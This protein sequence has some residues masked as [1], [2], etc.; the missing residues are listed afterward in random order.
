MSGHSLS[1]HM[2]GD[3]AVE[4]TRQR[5]P[6]VALA[7][8][9]TCV[10]VSSYVGTLPNVPGAFPSLLFSALPFIAHAFVVSS[11]RLHRG[12]GYW[13]ILAFG[14]VNLTI[15]PILGAALSMNL[16]GFESVP[17]ESAMT[18]TS[19]LQAAVFV[20][21]IV[22]YQFSSAPSPRVDFGRPRLSLGVMLLGLG[23][24]G[25]WLRIDSLGGI[26]AYLSGQSIFEAGEAGEA[27]WLGLATTVLPPF[28]VAGWMVIWECRPALF[29]GLR[30]WLLIL[31]AIL[32]MFLYSFNRAAVVVTLVSI[33]LAA[34]VTPEKPIR[35]GTI[36]C[37][38][39]VLAIGTWVWGEW[40]SGFWATAGGRRVIMQTDLI[41]PDRS[42]WDV[43]QVYTASLPRAASALEIMLTRDPTLANSFL[44]AIPGLGRS[45]RPGS[46][47]LIYNEALYGSGG[48]VDQILPA[49]V[50]A[51]ASAPWVAPILLFIG[52]GILLRR[53]EPTAQS[54]IAQSYFG[55]YVC[56]WISSLYVF[57]V[58]VVMQIVVFF[59][60]PAVFY[61]AWRR[62]GRR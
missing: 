23:L 30:R 37:A 1:L 62:I 50:E 53:F 35:R 4:W 28:W 22:G 17:T 59:L 29:I 13:L 10:A 2:V 42:V 5:L 24:M 57:S 36:V 26:S 8:A 33:I 48:A 39:V 19:I 21:G 9:L 49:F 7:L 40:R 27:G 54:S 32:P 14:V 25:S 11:H 58:S 56:I 38:G 60:W 3:P 15:N 12:P 31:L 20:A 44:A 16:K 55:W 6:V 46:G 18:T 52:A 41:A 43:W 51:Q 34:A 45:W 61:W 47:P